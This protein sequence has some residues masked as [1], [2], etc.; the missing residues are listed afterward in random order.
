MRDR[1]AIGL[2][3]GIVLG[4]VAGFGGLLMLDFPMKMSGLAIT[5]PYQAILLTNGLFLFARVERQDSQRV[6]ITDV[7]YVQSQ[8]NPETKQ[9]SNT[10]IKRGKEWHGPDRMIINPRHILLRESVGPD[11][12]VAKMIAERKP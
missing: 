4:V 11:S 3:L 9:L 8:V 10:L 12:A 5:T 6:A 2:V 7:Y 1:F